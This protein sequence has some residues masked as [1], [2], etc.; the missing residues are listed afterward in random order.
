MIQPS[1]VPAPGKDEYMLIDD[2][3]FD[4]ILIPAYFLYDGASIP[5]FA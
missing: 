1:V 5:W 3:P 2:Y 4:K